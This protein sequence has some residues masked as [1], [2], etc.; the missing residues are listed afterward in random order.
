MRGTT[1]E[2]AMLADVIES[3]SAI[4]SVNQCVTG[5]QWHEPSSLPLDVLDFDKST[6]RYRRNHW[7]L[8]IFLWITS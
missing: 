6:K 4:S 8:A 2:V 7:I 1:P 5:P 3:H